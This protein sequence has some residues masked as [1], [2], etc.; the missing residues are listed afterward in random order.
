MAAPEGGEGATVWLIPDG[1]LPRGG[2]GFASHEAVCILNTGRS[3]AH[4]VLT[5][6][7]ADR[8][9]AVSRPV[10]VRAESDVHLHLDVPE[11]VGGLAI[12]AETPYGL[13]V[14]SDRPVVVQMSR[15]DTR[16]GGMALFT[17]LGFP[18]GGRSGA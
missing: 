12:P 18:A 16:L 7:F 10:T 1:Y 2:T 3:D 4:V 17:S 13:R 14:E 15:M 6:Y 8:P 11:E 9:P 5:A